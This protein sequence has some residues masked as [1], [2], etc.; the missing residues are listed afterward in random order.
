MASGKPH[1]GRG[2]SK[3]TKPTSPPKRVKRVEPADELLD[4]MRDLPPETQQRLNR[5]GLRL[6]ASIYRRVLIPVIAFTIVL[7]IALI[8]QSMVLSN[9]TKLV[10]IDSNGRLFDVP[11]Q[12]IDEFVYSDG[13][14][15][16]F[17]NDCAIDTFDIRFNNYSRKLERVSS[18]CYTDVG[19][20]GLASALGPLIQNMTESTGTLY[21]ELVGN[22]T[23][24]QK[25]I[26]KWT[27]KMPVVITLA[28]ANGKP[29][30]TRT[31]LYY[32]IVK[33]N[34]PDKMRGLGI[35]QFVQRQD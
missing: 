9:S 31:N 5:I 13:R 25:S 26:D 32:T 19:K 33:E 28:P 18:R 23:L 29:I 16:N 17:A 1:Q 34:S 22:T 3:S 7:I 27:V 8:I 20:K 10:A 4:A 21:L 30:T 11:L 35:Q 2:A 14:V 24:V 15:I 12:S 6:Q